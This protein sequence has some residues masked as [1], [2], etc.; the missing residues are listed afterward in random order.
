MHTHE[1]LFGLKEEFLSFSIRA[2][3]NTVKCKGPRIE[4]W[5]T[6]TKL[7]FSFWISISSENLDFRFRPGKHSADNIFKIF[8]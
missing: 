2:S 8:L 1:K 4:A 7:Y 3:I 6:Q 5:G